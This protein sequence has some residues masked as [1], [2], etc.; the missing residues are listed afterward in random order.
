M[1]RTRSVGAQACPVTSV[2]QAAALFSAR[3]QYRMGIV[4]ADGDEGRIHSGATSTAIFFLHGVLRDTRRPDTLLQP[5]PDSVSRHR[6]AAQCSS[7]RSPPQVRRHCLLG[8]AQ[9]CGLKSS[10]IPLESGTQWLRPGVRLAVVDSMPAYRAT[11]ALQ[12]L[13]DARIATTTL[14]A[15]PGSLR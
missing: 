14:T 1:P 13:G 3:S 11:A 5:S 12:M 4:S 9:V 8:N 2:A 15:G 6:G 10:P 7:C